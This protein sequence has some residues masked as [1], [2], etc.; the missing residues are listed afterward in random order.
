[1]TEGEAV[2]RMAV[3]G[4]TG[5]GSTLQLP[6]TLLLLAPLSSVPKLLRRHLTAVRPHCGTG[7]AFF[8]A[9][10]GSSLKYRSQIVLPCLS[11]HA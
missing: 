10:S 11:K 3:A 2:A 6:Q 7:G 8:W 9:S 1:V 4:K 5:G